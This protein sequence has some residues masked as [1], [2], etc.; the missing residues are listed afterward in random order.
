[1]HSSDINSMVKQANILGRVARG[2]MGALKSAPKGALIGGGLGMLAAPI[3]GLGLAPALGVGGAG[4]FSG[5]MLGGG[6]RGAV[7]GLRGFLKNPSAARSM[8]IPAGQ[9]MAYNA[10][11]ALPAAAVGAGLGYMVS[12]ED[13][14]LMGTAVG[15]AGGLLARPMVMRALRQRAGG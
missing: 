1:M 6:I 3:V 2:T 11:S 10:G 7:G 15:V 4:A 13:N 12:D 8:S 9:R 14:K 5:A